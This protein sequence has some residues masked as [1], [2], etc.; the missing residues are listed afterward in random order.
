MRFIVGRAIIRLVFALLSEDALRKK[1]EILAPALLTDAIFVFVS[2]LL[3]LAEE[4]ENLRQADNPPPNIEQIL[5]D[6][7]IP[8]KTKNALGH[9]VVQVTVIRPNAIMKMP[10][11]NDQ[12]SG[13]VVG[14]NEVMTCF[15]VLAI[16]HGNAYYIDE[17][18]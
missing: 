11:L 4:Q 15:H 16:T 1:S 3:L 2:I 12:G 17:V 13:F 9:G 18:Y 8:P 10:V 6:D 14:E 5:N 7:S